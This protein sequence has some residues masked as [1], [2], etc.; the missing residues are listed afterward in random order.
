MTVSSVFEKVKKTSGSNDKKAILE[1]NKRNSLLRQALKSALDPF[2]PFNVVKVPKVKTRLEFPLP[3]LEAWPAFF[4]VLDECASR[5]VTG[6]A[7]IESVYTLFSSVTQ[8]NEKWMRKVL[9]KHLAI[10]VSTKSVNKVFPGLIP[11]F[12]V[13]LAQKYEEKRT[14]GKRICIEPKLDGIRCI[15]IVRDNKVMMFARSGKQITNFDDSIGKELSSLPS[16]VYDG[17][18]MGKD[19][20]ALMRQAY[21]KEEVD[22]TGTYFAMFDYLTINEWDQKKGFY[23]CEDRYGFLLSHA[24]IQ[25]LIV[26]EICVNLLV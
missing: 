10:G 7:A 18:I 12:D 24:F 1:E 4:A 16:G 22:V 19:F 3:E 23:S 11:T 17:E 13:S 26:S 25:T 20:I 6:N 9:K 8:E 14:E 2:T 5:K 21:R 15:A